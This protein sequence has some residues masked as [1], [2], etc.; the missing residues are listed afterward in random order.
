[1]EKISYTITMNCSAEKA[2]RTMLE[3]EQFKKWTALFNPASRYEGSWEEGSKI[4]FIG[5]D[6]Q[7]KQGGMLSRIKKNIPNEFVSIE[8]YGVIENGEEI[9]EGEKVKAFA[10]ALE[11][12]TFKEE[13]GKTELIVE[14]DT[15][16]DWKEYFSETW[17]KA[18]QRLKELCER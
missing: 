4:R 9:T 8:H 13:N 14:I 18:L 10:G 3:K 15:D 2:Y 5:E 16:E 6:E 17:P 7:G 1:M 11:N 12:Y